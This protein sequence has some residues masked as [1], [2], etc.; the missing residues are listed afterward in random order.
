MVVKNFYD[1]KNDNELRIQGDEFEA[2]SDRAKFLI[3]NGY[4]KEVKEK[5]TKMAEQ[6]G[7]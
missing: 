6:K 4:V 2:D 5:K 1:R 7:E 3:N